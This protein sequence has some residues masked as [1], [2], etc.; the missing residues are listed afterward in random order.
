MDMFLRLLKLYREKRKLPEHQG[1][2]ALS[3]YMWRVCSFIGYAAIVIIC[4]SLPIIFIIAAISWTSLSGYAFGIIF[5]LLVCLSG[6]L[7]FLL[8]KRFEA[9]LLRIEL[10]KHKAKNKTFS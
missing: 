10:R 6:I 8:A 2:S 3:F 4:L 9:I 7:M 1:E 5:V